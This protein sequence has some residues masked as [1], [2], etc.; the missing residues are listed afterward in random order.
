MNSG[1]PARESLPRSVPGMPQLISAPK[2]S[3]DEMYMSEPNFKASATSVSVIC[4][5]DLKKVR[6]RF[7]HSSST[8]RIVLLMVFMTLMIVDLVTLPLFVSWGSQT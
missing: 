4:S 8:S 6:W 1:R 3:H 7:T 5:I 2:L